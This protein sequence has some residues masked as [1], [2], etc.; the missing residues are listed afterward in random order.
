MLGLDLASNL[1][2]KSIPVVITIIISNLFAITATPI[3]I[4]IKS[5]F[6]KI[7]Y[8]A[9]VWTLFSPKINQENESP[10]YFGHKS[11][12]FSNNGHAYF[13]W[14]YKKYIFENR[15]S[16]HVWDRT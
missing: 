12:T 15:E 5:V 3:F 13:Y 7:E 4:A 14:H 16:G 2:K 8:V 9:N 10:G 11:T 6:L 1:T